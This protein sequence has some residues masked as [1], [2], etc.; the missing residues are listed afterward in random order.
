MIRKIVFISY[1]GGHSNL[2]KPIIE[3]ALKNPFNEIIIIPFNGAIP[4]YYRFFNDECIY[5]LSK[6]LFLFDE[7][8][9]EI[10]RFGSKLLNDNFNPELGITKFESICYLGLSFFDLVNT[11]GVKAAELEYASKKRNSFNPINVIYKILKHIKPTIVITTNSPRFEAASLKAASKLNIKSIQLLDLFGD[12]Y[13][14]PSA[15]FIITLNK[16]VSS[17]VE[18]KVKNNSTILPFGQPIFDI[19]KLEVSKID[20]NKLRLKL[21]IPESK[22]ILFCPSKNFI[23]NNDFSLKEINDSHL[24]NVKIFTMFERLILNR[25]LTIIIRTHPSDS[26]DFYLPYF[27]KN[28]SF[29]YFKDLNIYETLAISDACVSYNS[30]VLVQSL[31]CGKLSFPFNQDPSNPYLWNDFQISPFIY[32][33]NLEELENNIESNLDTIISENELNEFYNF[34]CVDKIISLLNEI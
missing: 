1:G 5:P 31:I 34:G 26:I 23:F 21:N 8:V 2:L 25:N 14:I 32:S 13:P 10:L 7:N 28:N 19:T 6:F 18:R 24:I 27:D 29:K 30:T 22:V 4:Y 17:K 9:D 3:E 12:E 16:N 33:S 15:D 20:S 11:L